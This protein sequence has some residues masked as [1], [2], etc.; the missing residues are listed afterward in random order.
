[1]RCTMRMQ[2]LVL[3]ALGV[4]MTSGLAAVPI[5][6]RHLSPNTLTLKDE[7][8]LQDSARL[9]KRYHLTGAPVADG[10][11]LSGILSR[12]DL[13]VAIDKEFPVEISADDFTKKIESLQ[14]R[15]VWQVMASQPTTISPD[16]TLLAAARLMQ[17]KK[18][19]RLMTKST[20]SSMLGIIS[21]TDVVFA[22]LKCDADA[23]AGIDP[24]DFT[25]NC[26]AD[27][28]D[29]E[30]SSSEEDE[31]SLGTT[32]ESYMS[33]CLYVIP[34]SM[35]LKDAAR[36]LRATGVTGAPVVDEDE[37]LVGVI[38]RNDLLKALLTIPSD[39]EAAGGE[40]FAEAIAKIEKTAVADVMTRAS[41]TISPQSTMLKAAKLLAR[42][43]LNRLMVVQPD[44]G[45][46]CGVLSSTDVVFA[47][48]GC[49]AGMDDDD[50]DDSIEETRTGNLYRKGI[51]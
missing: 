42:E 38:S 8:S 19:N 6:S 32:V 49:G 21:S 9:L 20:Y 41:I 36:L 16:E 31:C 30:D 23:A 39:V 34:P 26:A 2:V 18:L 17:S 3:G 40:A 25:F 37:Q 33:S 50:D 44:S 45:R 27:Y 46:L 22:L 10:S 43:K 35:S 13:L 14:Q 48:L 7:D 51:Y 12:N 1:M 29:E 24:D 15:Q 11:S 28:E 5:V 4:S 47:M